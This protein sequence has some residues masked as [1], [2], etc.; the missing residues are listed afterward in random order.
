M[1]HAQRDLG[2]TP[3]LLYPVNVWHGGLAQFPSLHAYRDRPPLSRVSRMGLIPV[4]PQLSL[5]RQNIM[6]KNKEAM[7]NRECPYCHKKISLRQCL[8]Y[9]LR[10]TDHDTVCNHCGRRV[11]LAREPKPGFAYSF[12]I[13]LMSIYL[14]MQIS[15]YV[16][17]TTFVNALLYSLPFFIVSLA[18]IAYTTLHGLFFSGDI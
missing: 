1:G 17:H 11:K 4:T 5:I 7:K 9:L 12:L 6:Y 14:P 18:I 3:Y 2:T 15:L 8:I 13:G 16:F 10:G